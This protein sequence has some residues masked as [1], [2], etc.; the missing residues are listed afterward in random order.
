MEQVHED[1]RKFTDE[2][3]NAKE[4]RKRKQDDAKRKQDDAKRKQDDY[5]DLKSLFTLGREYPKK[6]LKVNWNQCRLLLYSA[7]LMEQVEEDQRKFTDELYNAKEIRKEQIVDYIDKKRY[8]IKKTDPAI[9]TFFKNENGKKIKD[10]NFTN[11]SYRIDHTIKGEII[12]DTKL[13][14]SS[15]FFVKLLMPKQVDIP[16]SIKLPCDFYEAM[17]NGSGYISCAPFLQHGSRVN[18][19]KDEC[20]IYFQ[21]EF[22]RDS[23]R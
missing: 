8:D 16:E 10:E 2:L 15:C 11:H 7:T 19:E 22:T 14:G 6:N 5:S 17:G 21:R 4:I 18:D 3:Y 12:E 23:F 13:D 9:E 1:Q 20:H